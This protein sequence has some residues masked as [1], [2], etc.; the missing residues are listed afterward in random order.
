MQAG[1]TW[2]PVVLGRPGHISLLFIGQIS[3]LFMGPISVL[4]IDTQAHQFARD[5]IDI[6]YGL[7]PTEYDMPP[8]FLTFFFLFFVHSA[9]GAG[10]SD[11]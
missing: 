11:D 8:C 6:N 4:F 5:V 10:G 3:L 2:P 9:R 1:S 7:R